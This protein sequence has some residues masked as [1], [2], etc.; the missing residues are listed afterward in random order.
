MSH[1]SYEVALGVLIAIGVAASIEPLGTMA[2][3]RR[4]GLG[5]TGSAA[6][7]MLSGLLAASPA[8]AIS[9]VMLSPELQNQARHGSVPNPNTGAPFRG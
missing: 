9:L 4:G 3:N 2:A 6:S 7:A 1:C 8:G 5:H